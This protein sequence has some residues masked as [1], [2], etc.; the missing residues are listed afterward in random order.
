MSKNASANICVSDDKIVRELAYFVI[1]LSG[2][3]IKDLLSKF[4]FH[5]LCGVAMFGCGAAQ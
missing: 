1:R 2:C 3:S 5:S 4:R